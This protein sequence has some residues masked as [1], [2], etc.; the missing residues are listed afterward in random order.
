MTEELK[1]CYYR[2]LKEWGTIDGYLMD[3]CLSAQDACKAALD[4][5]KIQY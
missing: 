5:F 1:F 4:Y 3:T 2:G